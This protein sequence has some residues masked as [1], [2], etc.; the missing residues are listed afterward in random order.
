MTQ[1]PDAFKAQMVKKLATPDG[2]SASTLSQ[3]VGV[4]QSTLSK[5]LRKADTVSGM[6]SQD[7]TRRPQDWPPAEKLEVVVEAAGLSPEEL[8]SLV[9]R[10]GIHRTHLEQWHRQMLAGLAGGKKKPLEARRIRELEKELNRKDKALAEAA[11]LLVLKKKVQAIWGD[12]DT[13]TNRRR[14]K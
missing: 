8:G 13:T 3:E 5:W 12:E 1:Y 9:R 4:S 10:K 7:K 6:K 2:P 11:A 14:G